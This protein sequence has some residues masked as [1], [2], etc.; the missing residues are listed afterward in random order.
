MTSRERLEDLFDRAEGALEVAFRSHLSAKRHGRT[1]L[2]NLTIMRGREA[3]C[4]MER[5]ASKLSTT[6]KDAK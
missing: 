2:A 4:K 3:W 1:I 6:G 5:L